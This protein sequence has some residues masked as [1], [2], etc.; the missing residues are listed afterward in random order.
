MARKKQRILFFPFNLLSHYLRCLMLAKTYDQNVFEI[1]FLSS[2]KYNG[3]VQS[4]GYEVFSCAS[5]DADFV[6]R[7][8]NNFNFDWLNE[9]DLE[10]VLI[11]QVKCINAMQAN[12]VIGDVAPTL[13]MAAQLAGVTHINL[14]NGYMTR[15]YAAT[16]KIP[17]KHKAYELMQQLPT[18]FAEM[19]TTVGERLAFRKIQA[20]F[21][22]LRKKYNLPQVKDY[23]QELEGS[24]NLICDMPELFPQKFLPPAYRFIGPLVYQYAQDQA[25]WQDQVNWTKPLI[26]VCMGSTGSWAQLSFLNDAYYSRYT[27]ITAG[28]NAGVLSADHIIKRDF[29]NLNK[30][31]QKASLLICHGGNGT[32]YTGILNRVFMLCMASHF[33]QEYN[34][35]AL[36]RKGYGK[37]AAG[38]NEVDWKAQIH[39]HCS[40]YKL[41][42]P[43]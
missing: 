39:F 4:H 22:N 36:E 16:R 6:M 17:R 14:V 12:I 27:I 28:D 5:F 15:Y 33:E 29:I 26:C 31:L 9:K 20:P 3:F 19:L 38:F 10:R 13:K 34:V 37:S 2:E 40:R 35:E 41:K 18:A 23:L 7:C 21:N 1:R 24:E 8:T 30:V 43:A 32:I 11:G 42:Q 25:D